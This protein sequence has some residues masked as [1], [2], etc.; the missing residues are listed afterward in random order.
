MTLRER[1][2]GKKGR[3]NGRK[4][5]ANGKPLRKIP[6]AVKNTKEERKETTNGTRMHAANG[7][8][9]RPPTRTLS[10]VSLRERRENKKG[11][12]RRLLTCG[13]GGDGGGKKGRFE[14]DEPLEYV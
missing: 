3:K 7:D 4:H 13:F 11:K 1:G 9:R 2:G 12:K 8:A 5:P 14:D 10:H 6:F